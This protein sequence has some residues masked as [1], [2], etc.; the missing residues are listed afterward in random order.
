MDSFQ[1]YDLV[2]NDERKPDEEKVLTPEDII[3]IFSA[4]KNRLDI[5]S[6]ELHNFNNAEQVA[7]LERILDEAYEKNKD[8]RVKLICGNRIMGTDDKNGNSSNPLVVMLAK[9]PY[10]ELYFNDWELAAQFMN[11]YTHGI[12]A[13][14]GKR[15][16]FEKPHSHKKYKEPEQNID[17][18]KGLF[19][20]NY[21]DFGEE[22]IKRNESFAYFFELPKDRV[23]LIM[24]HT[25][26]LVGSN[27]KRGFFE[28]PP[29]LDFE[30][31]EEFEAVWASL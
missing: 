11:G 17:T 6:G 12:I 29:E 31:R 21:T 20:N 13:D 23:D 15:V 18:L 26:S 4:A 2:Y 8:F 14:S 30:T 22:L 27:G 28:Y 16:Y 9:K 7:L 1:Y 5:Y 24:E 25:Y 3:S 19:Y 10:A